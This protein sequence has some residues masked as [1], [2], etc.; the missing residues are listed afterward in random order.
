MAKD[1]SSD[2]TGT[3]CKKYVNAAQVSGRIVGGA[4]VM[5]GFA[6]GFLIAVLLVQSATAQGLFHRKRSS[7]FT[8]QIGILDRRASK[9]NSNS[10]RLQ[11]PQ[12][13]TPTKWDSQSPKYEGNYN[14][15]YLSV[16]KS[17]ARKHDVPEG[18]FLR[19]VQQES[20]WNAKA[21]SEKGA[22][23]LAQLMPATARH[24]GV[25]RENPAEN[26]EGGA[27]YL[28]QQY[29]KFGSWPLALAAYNAGP[30]AVA[31][32]GGVPPFKETRNYVRIIW[33]S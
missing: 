11:P 17:A 26:L 14:G 30:K 18:L 15:P 32:Y 3:K 13:I 16:A 5:R 20:G 33:G 19:L 12:V 31:K 6:S 21:L 4:G 2:K 22:Y 8:S 27:R 25:D 24:L 10:I 29:K 1:T 28:S 9:Q 23:G 7:M